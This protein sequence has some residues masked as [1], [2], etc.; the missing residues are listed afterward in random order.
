MV[1]R[2]DPHHMDYRY[3]TIDTLFFFPDCL[4]LNQIVTTDQQFDVLPRCSA[5]SVRLH[6]G[7]WG[8]LVGRVPLEA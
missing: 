6:S 8:E 5:T 3:Y 4:L 7:W 2:Y 1:I